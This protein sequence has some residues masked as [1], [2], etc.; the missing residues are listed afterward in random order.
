MPSSNAS[1]SEFLG[2]K[3]ARY[4]PWISQRMPESWHPCLLTTAHKPQRWRMPTRTR[5]QNICSYSSNHISR[6][7]YPSCYSPS[8]PLSQENPNE[9]SV[10][11]RSTQTRET[12][13]ELPKKNKQ[14]STNDTAACSI[15]TIQDNI[16]QGSRSHHLVAAASFFFVVLGL[17]S[18][19]D[20]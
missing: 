14:A 1:E 9:R 10:D 16:G 12:R 7:K 13:R 11:R 20:S 18:Y 5:S 15:E 19:A 2:I 4:P 17:A 6:Y 8:H 3:H